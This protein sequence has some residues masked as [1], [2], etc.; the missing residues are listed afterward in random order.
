MFSEV[1]FVVFANSLKNLNFYA[2]IYCNKSITACDHSFLATIGFIAPDKI[3]INSRRTGSI[4]WI[5]RIIRKLHHAA[6]KQKALSCGSR[7][8][9]G[10]VARKPESLDITNFFKLKMS[11]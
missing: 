6:Y 11:S 3:L 5:I 9:V 10:I 4:I 7:Q 8:R 2:T 1:F